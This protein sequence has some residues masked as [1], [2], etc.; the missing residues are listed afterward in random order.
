ML[1]HDTRRVPAQSKEAT[2]LHL[3]INE[4]IDLIPEDFSKRTEMIRVLKDRQ[5]SIP[6]TAPDAMSGRWQEV[7]RILGDY[8][9][10]DADW[11]PKVAEI[12]GKELED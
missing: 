8:I 2:V 9:P 12:F 4:M 6:Y 5:S 3:R 10:S 7:S 1:A 11:G